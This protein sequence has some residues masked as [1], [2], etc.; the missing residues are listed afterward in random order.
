MKARKSP[1]RANHKFNSGDESDSTLGQAVQ[2]L[3]GGSNTVLQPQG[4]GGE[5]HTVTCTASRHISVFLLPCD[6]TM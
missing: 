4:R 6:V 3:L 2:L 5:A 1:D